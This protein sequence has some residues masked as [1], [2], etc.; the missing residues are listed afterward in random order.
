MKYW[1]F[2]SYNAGDQKTAEVLHRALETYKLPAHLVGQPGGAG[3]IPS[4]LKP[5]FIDRSELR[6]AS[7]VHGEILPALKESRALIVLCSPGAAVSGWVDQEVREFQALGRHDRVFPVVVDGGPRGVVKDVFP[8]PLRRVRNA[9]GSITEIEPLA[10]DLKKDGFN[11]TR[12]KLIAG[13]LGL[14]F[15]ALKQRDQI[16]KRKRALSQAA[17]TLIALAAISLGYVAM[18]DRG[19]PGSYL[20]GDQIRRYLDRYDLSIFRPAA[21]AARIAE[22]LRD[23]RREWVALNLMEFNTAGQVFREESPGGRIGGVWIVGQNLSGVAAAPEATPAD[24]KRATERMEDP[25]KPGRAVIDEKGVNYGW[26]WY[27]LEHPQAENSLWAVIALSE[28]LVRPGALTAD[29][30]KRFIEHLRFSEEAASL[31]YGDGGW[32][33]FPNQKN[34]ALYSLYTSVIGLE[35]LLSA[36]KATGDWPGHDLRQ[37]IAA[38][39]RYLLTTYDAAPEGHEV[40]GWRGTQQAPDVSPNAALTLLAYSA[41]LRATQANP[42]LVRIPPGMLAD[43]AARVA[44]FEADSLKLT[45]TDED[46]VRASFVDVEG[47]EQNKEYPWKLMRYPYAVACAQAWLAHLQSQRAGSEDIVAARRVLGKLV[48][49]MKA[50]GDARGDFYRAEALWILDRIQ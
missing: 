17:L 25:F 16:R 31:Y 3:P 40:P 37:M 10:A 6:G 15:D 38:T 9:D 45:T 29:E 33:H 20:A 34:R 50:L 12:L 28:F 27:K 39:S 30:R 49:H 23:V 46:R 14:D 2:I 36:Q 7:S 48:S 41:L 22:T 13:I 19:S 44:E 11:N 1:A 47:R 18:V 21:S 42:D 8:L 4:D 35:A 43:I 24:L 5:V 26:L 32:M